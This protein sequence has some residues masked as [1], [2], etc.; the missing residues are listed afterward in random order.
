[1]TLGEL[2]DK[3]GGKLAQGNPSTVLAGVANSN[4]AQPTD[5]V[6]AEDPI[7]ATEALAS[8]AGSPRPQA[9]PTPSTPTPPTPPSP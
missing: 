8:P 3:L 7:S 4:S 5:L 6:F 1:M 9:L 2:I